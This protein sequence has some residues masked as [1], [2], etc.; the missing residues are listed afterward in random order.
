MTRGILVNVALI[1]KWGVSEPVRGFG[2]AWAARKHAAPGKSDKRAPPPVAL[3]APTVITDLPTF[4]P[5]RTSA[6]R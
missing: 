1:L 4:A 5:A 3:D 6:M 2:L